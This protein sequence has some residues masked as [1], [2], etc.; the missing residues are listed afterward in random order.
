MRA[1]FVWLFALA[2]CSVATTPK[3]PAEGAAPTIDRQG[4]LAI[5]DEAG[6]PSVVGLERVRVTQATLGP[7]RAPIFGDAW[8]LSSRPERRLW[9]DTL[10]QVAAPATLEEA[11]A[12]ERAARARV[13]PALRAPFVGQLPTLARV[14]V[15]DFGAALRRELEDVEALVEGTDEWLDHRDRT[16][17]TGGA[18]VYWLVRARW[19]FA[20]GHPALASRALAQVV[21]MTSR[22]CE[23]GCTSAQVI[24]DGLQEVLIREAYEAIR[25][26]APWDAA[27]RLAHRAAALAPAGRHVDEARALLTRIDALAAAERS[28]PGRGD[29]ALDD[30]D[31]VISLLREETCKRWQPRWVEVPR[32]AWSP[33]WELVGRGDA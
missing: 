26:R 23:S 3:T 11:L 7:D 24:R 30:D 10:E 18:P 32:F 1:A 5:Y 29:D 25:V 4:L 31:A 2:A 22:V 21:R 20:R 28:P 17:F 6:L 9:L 15:I 12:A 16:R 8:V 13:P 14:E 27:R 19:A 33:F